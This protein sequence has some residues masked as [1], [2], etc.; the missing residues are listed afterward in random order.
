MTNWLLIKYSDNYADEFDVEGFWIM[1]KAKW[2]HEWEL[3]KYGVY[4]VKVDLGNESIS[5]DT[6]T[7]LME[8]LQ[9]HSIGNITARTLHNVVAIDG[10]F[11]LL[12]ELPEAPLPGEISTLHKSAYCSYCQSMAPVSRKTEDEWKPDKN[13][14]AP[15]Y[16]FFSHYMNPGDEQDQLTLCMGSNEAVDESEF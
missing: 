2:Q 16:I 4:P 14:M 9:V 8:T 11:G 10:H 15:A 12:P 1:A 3:I 5:Y 6:P 13:E 7:Q